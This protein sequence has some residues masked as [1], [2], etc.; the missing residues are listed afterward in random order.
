MHRPNNSDVHIGNKDSR[1]RQAADTCKVT[2][3]SS[4]LTE[5]QTRFTEL[6]Q[7]VQKVH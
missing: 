5:P 2:Q 3:R 6:L 4:P 1:L 7:I